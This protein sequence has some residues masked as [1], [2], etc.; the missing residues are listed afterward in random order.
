[1]I[2]IGING[3]GRIGRLI[4]RASL[5]RL[6]N[7]IKVVAVNDIGDISQNAHLFKYDTVHGKVSS[8][9]YIEDNHL[10]IDDNKISFFSQKSPETIPWSKCGTDIVL[11]CTGLFTD[12]EKAK[13][14]LKGGAKKV[15]ISAPSPNA[16]ITVVYGVNDKKI[17]NDHKIISNA[18]CTTNCLAP[19]AKVVH[20]K[21]GI[22]AGFMTTVHSFTS[23]QK[24]LDSIPRL[25]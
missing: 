7:D 25:V 1:M 13:G 10:A 19:I 22:N 21:F 14:H 5:E 17:N 11:E 9:I 4:L 6:K 2:N 24:I 20:E 18:S 23:D 16:D 15:L 3:F 8:K 12:C